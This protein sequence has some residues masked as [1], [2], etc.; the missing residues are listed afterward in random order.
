VERPKGESG[1]VFFS[2]F[3]GSSGLAVGLGSSIFGFT[4]SSFGA[5]G[6]G[7]AGCIAGT[8]GAGIFANWM[9]T[10]VACCG[11]LACSAA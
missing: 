4:S 7:A 6:F 10:I 11:G 3:F 8:A 9:L 5:T 2:G 1:T